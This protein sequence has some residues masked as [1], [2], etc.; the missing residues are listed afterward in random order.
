MGASGGRGVVCLVLE[1]RVRLWWYS[2]VGVVEGER[3]VLGVLF[4]E[5]EPDFDGIRCAHR[6]RV[7]N[8]SSSLL[9]DKQDR[10]LTE[11]FVGRGG[12]SA[13]SGEA[14][15]GAGSAVWEI[16]GRSFFGLFLSQAGKE[17]TRPASALVRWG[18]GGLCCERGGVSVPS[19]FINDRREGQKQCL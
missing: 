10:R 17:E 5:N 13:L 15:P 9:W 14:L 6:C 4:S 1:E 8:S 11:L 12:F 18:D 19:P 7:S 16:F 3:Q 2:V